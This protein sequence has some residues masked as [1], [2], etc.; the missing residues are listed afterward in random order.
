MYTYTEPALRD[1][2]ATFLEF[3][4]LLAIG[5]DLEHAFHT[6]AV[7]E[8]ACEVYLTARQFGEPVRELPS[9]QVEWIASYWR[10]QF[11]GAPAPLP[12]PEP[13]PAPDLQPV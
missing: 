10:A 3:H 1:R 8:G 11:P 5:A 9:E 13:L 7:V 12:A 4:G 2:G 6:A